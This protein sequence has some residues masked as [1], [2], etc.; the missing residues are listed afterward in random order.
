MSAHLPTKAQ[1]TALLPQL[2]AH[3]RVWAEREFS[4]FDDAV[5]SQKPKDPDTGSIWDVPAIDSKR[6]VSLLAELE[7]LIGGGCKLPVSA[8]K[9]GGYA[10]TEDLVSKLFPKLCEKCLDAQ[11][12][13]VVSTSASPPT[14]VQSPP[15]QVLP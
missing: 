7:T 3:A 9:S 11:K 15:P 8:I 2:E 10:N 5:L 14:A 1:L 4:S 6:V 12:P 13:G